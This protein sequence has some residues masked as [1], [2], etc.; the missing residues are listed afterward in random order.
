[1]SI[2]TKSTAV[3]GTVGIV[4]ALA[5]TAPAAA[6]ATTAHGSWAQGHFLSGSIAGLSL[7][8]IVG[9]TP[10]EVW[11]NGSQGTQEKVD[12]LAVS[13]LGSQAINVGAV[14]VSPDSV[15]HST[16]VGGALSQYAM[17]DKT[18]ATMG[19]SGTIGNGGAIGPNASNPNGALTLY[20]DRLIGSRF[21]AVITDLALKIQAIAANIHGNHHSVDGGYYIDG[22]TLSFT[23]PAL[24]GISASVTKAIA[25]ADAKL[26]SLGGAHGDL[27]V[28]LNAILVAANPALKLGANATVSISLE[29]NL[30]AVIAG[31]LSR[32]WGGAGV[33]FNVTTGKVTVDLNALV[34]GTLNNRP[35]NSELLT[36]ATVHAIIATV[37]S[38]VVSLAHQVIARVD[39]ALNNL[40]LDVDVDL[41]VLT[42]QAPIVGQSCQ[43]E[44]SHGN[45]LSEVL[46]KLLGHL[47]CTPTST[48][49][50]KLKTSVAVDVHGTVAQILSGQ[51]PATAAA[52]VLGIPV[53]LSASHIATSLGAVLKAKIFGIGGILSGIRSSC[54]GPLLDQA[55]AGLLG[56]AGIEGVLS[57]I[58]SLKVNVRDTNAGSGWGPVATNTVF[59]QTAM[60]VAVAPGTGS[61]GLTSVNL[62]SASVAPTM[63]G[64][65]PG[66]IG[67][68]GT[69]GGPGTI[70][71]PGTTETIPTGEVGGESTVQGS[72]AYTGVAIGSAIALLIALLITGA[73]LAR[74]GYRRNHPTLE[75]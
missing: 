9:L 10:A 39:V 59:S 20:L 22:L 34:G 68:P 15:L 14:R 26:A 43:Y 24:A 11:N 19:A 28:A 48:L 42:D 49:L 71:D 12:P 3:L 23:S 54:D 53:S 44:D 58:L 17:A 56:S 31:L 66:V 8:S 57:G 6:S 72:L 29:H 63:T 52:R 40:K 33:S 37:A 73:W 67:D 65:G 18:G 4:A 75:L 38:N 27:A 74:K 41:A 61:S 1:M 64:N 51:A 30:K 50:P 62:A 16:T 46:G 45:I 36:P 5:V 69:F 21:D 47:V 7:D 55:N 35:V 13:L 32:T 60:R 25:A 2:L 70:G